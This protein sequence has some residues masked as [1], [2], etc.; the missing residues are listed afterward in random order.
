[1]PLPLGG[2][3]PWIAYLEH[4]ARRFAD[5][6][7]FR[8]SCQSVAGGELR[9][10]TDREAR[11]PFCA[12]NIRL[13]RQTYHGIAGLLAPLAIAG[14]AA[15]LPMQSAVPGRPLLLEICPASFLRRLGLYG[16]FGPYKGAAPSCHAA[17]ER[18]LDAVIEA[19][20]LAPPAAGLRRTL[21]DNRG[22]DA[23]DSA[24]AAIACHRALQEPGSTGRG[25]PKRPSRPG[26]LLSRDRF[27]EPAG[28]VE[29]G[30]AR[31]REPGAA[32]DDRVSLIEEPPVALQ[33]GLRGVPS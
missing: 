29:H 30:L 24:F 5:A 15:V 13:Y 6:D 20:L 2:G 10:A 1:M 25:L 16:R 23:L 7:S 21:L 9:R 12:Y 8:A 33:R 11:V 3:M 26:L 19:G 18:L 14:R 22:G 17:R 4:F 28:V 32:R 27:D 31:R